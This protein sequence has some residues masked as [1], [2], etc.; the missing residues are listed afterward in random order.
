M[1]FLV[2]IQ[3]NTVHR[4]PPLCQTDPESQN[5]RTVERLDSL[6]GNFTK[7]SVCFKD[8]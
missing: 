7:C 3:S 5:V 2:N 8:G 1:A 4:D 6:E